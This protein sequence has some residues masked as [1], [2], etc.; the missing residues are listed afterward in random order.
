MAARRKQQLGREVE[1]VVMCAWAGEF[2]A[3]QC[4]FEAGGGG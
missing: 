4:P 3:R 2:E 1:K